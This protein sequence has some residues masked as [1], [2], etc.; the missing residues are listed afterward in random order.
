MVTVILVSRI[1]Q[2]SN[3]DEGAAIPRYCISRFDC[4]A[5][6]PCSASKTIGLTEPYNTTPSST[7]ETIPG[8]I[9]ETF[10]IIIPQALPDSPFDIYTKVSNFLETGTCWPL[11][12][13]RSSGSMCRKIVRRLYIEEP[14]QLQTMLATMHTIW[15]LQ[16]LLVAI[17]TS[18]P[19][20]DLRQIV[21]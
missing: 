18:L 4:H 2:T 15:H 9:S 1:Q 21:D 14:I 5:V 6:V 11:I 13:I 8:V 19:L 10:P 17:G 3:I 20:H 12:H 7:A 16:P